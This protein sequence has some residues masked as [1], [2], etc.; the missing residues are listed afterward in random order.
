VLKVMQAGV[1][2]ILAGE[3][4]GTTETTFLGNGL[5]CRFDGC[6]ILYREDRLR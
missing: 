3:I 6:G 1:R 2:R 5:A 4:R